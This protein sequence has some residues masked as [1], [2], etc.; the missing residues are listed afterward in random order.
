MILIGSQ[1]I[2]HWFPDFPRNP[3]DTD[4]IGEGQSISGVVEYHRN[5]VFVNYPHSIM[6]PSDLLTLKASH[7]FYDINW[8]KHMFDVQFLLKKGL[9][10]DVNLFHTL[11]SFWREYHGPRKES[12]LTLSAAEFF[13]NALKEYDHDYLHTLL[14]PIPTYTLVLKDG[15]EVEPDYN[16]FMD[17]THEQKIDLVREEVYVMAFERNGGRDYRAAYSW[18]LKK[19]I[20]HH[21][22][23]WEALFI[24][25]NYIELHK[26]TF[27][28]HKH[29][30][31]QLH[32]IE[33]N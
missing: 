23:V 24:I 29:L 21:A 13:D 4:Y 31:N 27:N 32:G 26:P 11:L 5:P 2:K 30:I 1:A 18:M 33:V 15:S 12:D 9:N 16:K 19:F 25:E 20:I 14:K 8:E 7:L 17:L 22:P 6:L 10:I 3:K 28:Y